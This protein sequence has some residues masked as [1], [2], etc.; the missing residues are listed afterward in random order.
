VI[1]RKAKGTLLKRNVRK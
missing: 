1:N